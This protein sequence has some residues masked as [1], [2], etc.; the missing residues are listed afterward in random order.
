MRTLTFRLAEPGDIGAIDALLAASYPRILKHDYPPSVIV[1]AVPIIARARPR[2]VTSGTYYV[3]EMSGE[4]IVGAGGWTMRAGTPAEGEIRHVVTDWRFVRQG[5]GRRLMTGIFA[6]AR[7]FGV[8]RFGCLATRSAVPFYQAMGF[9]RCG[10]VTVP[11]APAI[12]FPAVAM[13]R[14]LRPPHA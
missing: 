14:R 7:T 1:L 12:T 2:L 5:I 6:D 8:T 10:E 9:R 11:L 3:V 13:E 4:G